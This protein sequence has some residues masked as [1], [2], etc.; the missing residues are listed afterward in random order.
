MVTKTLRELYQ[1]DLR[2]TV[3]VL[4][5]APGSRKD[6]VAGTI[7]QLYQGAS[8]F[9]ADD[10]RST[11]EFSWDQLQ[12]QQPHDA[13]LRAF[14]DFVRT[15]PFGSTGVVANTHV[16]AV[17]AAPYMA[18]A[19]AYGFRPILVTLEADLA[20]A[21]VRVDARIPVAKVREMHRRVSTNTTQVPSMW[22]HYVVNVDQDP[23]EEDRE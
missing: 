15:S 7:L 2:G 13:C 11:R 17:E 21:L 1:E 6:E 19:V 8:C 10:F 16:T 5:G 22:T 3:V 18:L 12:H 9:S 14:A 23:S 20:L 4:R